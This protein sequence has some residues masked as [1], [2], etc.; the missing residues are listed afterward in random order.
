MSDK[1]SWI[2]DMFGYSRNTVKVSVKKPP[3]NW[4]IK[5]W[6]LLWMQANRK[7][8]RSLLLF[9]ILKSLRNTTNNE[10]MADLEQKWAWN[11]FDCTISITYKLRNCKNKQGSFIWSIDIKDPWIVYCLD[12]NLIFQI[13]HVFYCSV[14]KYSQTCPCGH[15]Y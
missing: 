3:I 6:I 10:N 1:L 5:H 2:F 4:S 14:W 11:S 13:K 7:K 15:L 9:F 12:C 8:Y